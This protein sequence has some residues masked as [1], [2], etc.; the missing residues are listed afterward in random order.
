QVLRMLRDSLTRGDPPSFDLEAVDQVIASG[1]PEGRA[2]IEFLVGWF[3]RKHGKPEQA[4]AYLRRC[5]RS[6]Y[7]YG[8]FQCMALDAL[9]GPG[10]V[11]EPARTDP[12]NAS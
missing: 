12:R 3:L 1:T 4:R 9:R 5:S 7:T 6:P 10:A 11:G 8:W 2:N